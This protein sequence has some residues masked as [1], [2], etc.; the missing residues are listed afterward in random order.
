MI[1]V[2]FVGLILVRTGRVAIDFKTHI[3]SVCAFKQKREKL[4]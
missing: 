1:I 4:R 2:N 3:A